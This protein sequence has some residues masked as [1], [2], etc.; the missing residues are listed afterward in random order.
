VTLIGETGKP[1]WFRWRGGEEYSTIARS[2]E[3]C[4]TVHTVEE[5]FI[6]LMPE[7]P[8]EEYRFSAQIRHEKSNKPGE[9]GIYFS[10]QFY[11]DGEKQNPIYGA[12]DIQ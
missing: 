8:S 10:H 9:V 7:V 1:K 3:D 11:E 5:C 12:T 6:E 2:R 4:F